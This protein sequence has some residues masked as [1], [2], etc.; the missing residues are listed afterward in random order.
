MKEQDYNK[1]GDKPSPDDWAEFMDQDE[2]FIEELNRVVTNDGIN[3]TKEEYTTETGDDT[4]LRMEVALPRY[5]DGP[6]FAKVTKRIRDTNGL[7]IGTANDNPPYSTQECMR[8]SIWT[9]TK[10]QC[11]PIT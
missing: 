4:Y 2:D 10:Q 8:L 6:Q 11:R 1:D 5:E 3:D 9:V 7:P